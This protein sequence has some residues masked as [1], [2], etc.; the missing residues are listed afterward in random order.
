MKKEI[1][2]GKYKRI[3][4]LPT[5]KKM[6][7]IDSNLNISNNTAYVFTNCKIVVVHEGFVYKTDTIHTTKSDNL[8]FQS[9]SRDVWVRF[10]AKDFDLNGYF[11]IDQIILDGNCPVK[12]KKQKLLINELPNPFG[13]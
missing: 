11:N 3:A 5:S 1:S 6:I 10:D 12:P 4:E 9:V 13:E 7:K 8:G 2:F